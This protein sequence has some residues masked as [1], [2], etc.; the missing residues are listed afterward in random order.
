MGFASDLRL[1]FLL[2]AYPVD[3]PGPM[4][5]VQ[6]PTVV[7][8]MFLHAPIFRAAAEQGGHVWNR[9]AVELADLALMR[10]A[11]GGHA[12]PL[13][14]KVKNECAEEL[15]RRCSF[16][17]VGAQLEAKYGIEPLDLAVP[18]GAPNDVKIMAIILYILGG[19]GRDYPATMFS[20]GR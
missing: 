8:I 18:D 6:W 15:W 3:D 13:T 12:G 17:I 4:E 11:E 5:L 19:P 16:S 14:L 9:N 1:M 7:E 10:M 2:R 20:R